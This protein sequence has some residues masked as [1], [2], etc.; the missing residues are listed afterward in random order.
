MVAASAMTRL[1]EATH[2]GHAAVEHSLELMRADVSLADYTRY[3]SRMLSVHA[4][5]EMQLRAHHALAAAVPR[6]AE[7]YKEALLVQDL[8][9]LDARPSAHAPL[10]EF[11]RAEHVL[12]ALYV[13]EGSTL[14]GKVILR[15]LE[16]VLGAR[17]PRAYLGAYGAEVGAMWWTFADFLNHAVLDESE[18]VAGAQTMFAAIGAWLALGRAPA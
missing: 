9:A 2:A 18:L 13:L 3:L 14:G 4:A 1:K 15:H 8:S 7:R 17:I 6:L 10:P 16:R 11:E 12:G 5:F